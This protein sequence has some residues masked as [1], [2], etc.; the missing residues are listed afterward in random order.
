MKLFKT[1]RC[2]TILGILVSM[3]FL[4]AITSTTA[5]GQ[6]AARSQ[7]ADQA[8]AD[9]LA[10]QPKPAP[11]EPPP[12]LLIKIPDEPK[13]IDPATFVPASLAKRVTVDFKEKPL[14]EIAKWLQDEQSLNVLIDSRS[15]AEEGILAGEPITDHS[16]NA[17]LYLLLNRLSAL[18]LDWYFED[19][20]LTITTNTAAQE[21]TTTVPYNVSDLFDNGYKSQIIVRTITS[22]I[23]GSWADQ[24]GEGG[25]IVVLGDVLFI[26]Q[27]EHGHQ[28]VAGLL[29]ALRNHGRMTYIA[30]PPEHEALRQ[31]LTQKVTVDFE[32][33]P[34]DAAVREIST[35]LK[36]DIR[37]NR[38][39]LSEEGVSELTPVTLRMKELPLNTVLRA[40]LSKLGLTWIL[41]DGVL[42]ITTLTAADEHWQT[43]VFD[44]RD[45]CRNVSEA[46][47]LMQAVRTQTL[48]KWEDTD[49]EGGSMISPKT[50]VLVVHNTQKTL[51]ELAKLLDSYRAALRVSKRRDADEINPK[52]VITKYYRLQKQVAGDLEK[53][54]PELVQPETWKSAARPDAVG[55]IRDVASTASLLSAS[56]GAP[57]APSPKLEPVVISNS[58]LIIKQSREVHDA[59]DKVIQKILYGDAGNTLRPPAATGMGGMGGMGG[60]MGGMGGGMGGMGG[61]FGGGFFAIPSK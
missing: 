3:I 34:L 5:Y 52:E 14:K 60:G 58:V 21:H 29:A 31:K 10:V 11:N 41:R 44:V 47:G 22:M 8:P 9:A 18:M 7:P 39:I 57:N 15:M 32:E 61:G 1:I 20:T 26:R 37:L 59:I 35:Q 36:A 43:A 40:F 49:G 24:D 23:R 4:L 54:L 2:D 42:E 6:F 53:L 46:Y 33:T 55:T 12:S 51:E 45:L 17:P 38:Q 50:G 13:T 25:T 16:E 30:D 27:T 19:N 28:H 48:G 56:E